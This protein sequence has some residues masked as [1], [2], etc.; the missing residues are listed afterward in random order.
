MSRHGMKPRPLERDRWSFELPLEPIREMIR[1]CC[2]TIVIAMARTRIVEAEDYFDSEQALPYTDRYVATEWTQIEAAMA[3]EL[4]H[5]IL[6][7]KEDRV[8]AEGLLDPAQGGLSV[9]SVSL[10]TDPAE[11]LRLIERELREFRKQVEEY[12]LLRRRPAAGL[13]I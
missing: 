7:F 5:P 2:G 3:F 1:E 11:R 8:H 10:R 9:V 6:I 13:G 12:A 4:D